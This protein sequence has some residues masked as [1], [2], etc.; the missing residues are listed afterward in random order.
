MMFQRQFLSV[1]R[2]GP[3]LRFASAAGT[4]HRGLSS[5]AAAPTAQEKLINAL[6]NYRQEK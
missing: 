4:A 1:M 6:E 5:V 2:R 3:S